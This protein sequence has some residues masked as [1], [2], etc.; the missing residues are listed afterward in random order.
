M[1]RKG[2]R[3]AA[4]LAACTLAGI[5]GYNVCALYLDHPSMYDYNANENSKLMTET[6]HEAGELE[7]R[8]WTVGVMYLRNLDKN[9]KLTGTKEF[10]QHTEEEMQR[11][12][13][14]DSGGNITIGDYS[15]F[16][17]YVS[18]DGNEISSTGKSLDAIKTTD[19]FIIENGEH[20]FTSDLPVSVA[21]IEAYD[22]SYGAHIYVFGGHMPCRRSIVYDFDTTGLPSWYV[23][24]A[25]YYYKTDGTTLVPDDYV[26]RNGDYDS[27]LGSWYDSE[28]R[29]H[30]TYVGQ[31]GSLYE[32]M[33]PGNGDYVEVQRATDSSKTSSQVDIY[34][35]YSVTENNRKFVNTPVNT[36]PLT[37]CI[38][39][40]AEFADT[41][42]SLRK[43]EKTEE[44]NIVHRLVETLPFAA[45]FVILALY[46]MWASGYNR[47][48]KKYVP[49]EADKLF[50]ELPLLLLIAAP[51]GIIGLIT[52]DVFKEL[53]K[54]FV[55]YYKSG[56]MPAFYAAAES[57]MAGVF[58]VSLMTLMTRLKCRTLLKTTLCGRIAGALWNRTKNVCTKAANRLALREQ[59][60]D[61]RMSRRFIIRSAAATVFGLFFCGMLLAMNSLP[62][63]LILAVIIIGAYVYFNLRDLS[64]YTELSSHITA[65][66]G[67]D[68]SRREVPVTSPVYGQTEKLN[69]ISDGLQT[70]VEK[71]LKS[72][73]MKIDLVTNVSHD[74]KTPLTSIISYIDLLA[75]EDLKPEARDF[76][77]II[78]QKA[79]RLR[80]MVSDVF[81]LAKATS[82][83]DMALERIDAV[84]LTGQVLGD[85]EDRIKSS[86]R[87]V[88]SSLE[89]TS[90]P[91]N[92]DGKKLYRVF[93]NLIDNALKYSLEGTRVWLALKE[94]AG[95]AVFT[96]KN[97]AS[98]EMNFTPEEITERFV[99]GDESRTS[100]GNGLG[101]SI[102]KSFTEACGGKFRV[103]IDGD[104]FGAE[105]SLPLLEEQA[106][107]EEAVSVNGEE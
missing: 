7:A 54:F 103:I 14:M 49:G 104:M 28:G 8:L 40:K 41:L 86:G 83:T 21:S 64:A 100:E 99:R 80:T 55:Q 29:Y 107:A 2:I 4:F 34:D 33:D 32:M 63:A 92:A 51:V 26:K 25:K 19:S 48:E 85:M 71:Q 39:P 58:L 65:M 94:Q 36:Y 30:Y 66:N 67:G 53:Y 73:R 37:V 88:R 43:T 11:L 52:P 12:G 68:Y 23:D 27:D 5:C 102:A 77:T 46:L 106:S 57:I 81:D 90:A 45:G 87:E 91:V 69:S 35:Y 105:V 76:V 59:L 89:L 24:D 18:W 42:E 93:Q 95:Y 13:L 10:R 101:L 60:R 78:Q 17:Y 31:N 75:Q 20:D 9:G 97:T 72:E 22:A 44:E 3:I 98:Y 82:R 70:A 96:V 6:A 62:G 47:K 56:Y 61:D 84:I 50:A 38:T 74:L 15:N 1:R 16:D 79:E